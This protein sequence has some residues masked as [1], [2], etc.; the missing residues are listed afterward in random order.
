MTHPTRPAATRRPTCPTRRGAPRRPPLRLRRAVPAAGADGAPP[1]AAARA[2]SEIVADLEASAAGWNRADMAAHLAI[3][4]DSATFMTATGPIVGKASTRS[5]LERAFW[6]DGRPK[7]Q[8]RFERV[9]V[10]PLGRAP[11]ARDRPVHALGRGR[12]GPERLVSRSPWERTP[13]GVARAARPLVVSAAFTGAGA[14]GADSPRRAADALFHAPARVLRFDGATSR[15]RGCRRAS[16]PTR[17]GAGLPLPVLTRASWLRAPPT[18]ARARHGPPA[19]TSDAARA[20]ARGATRPAPPRMTAAERALLER[21]AASDGGLHLSHPRPRRGRGRRLRGGGGR[22]CALYARG[23]AT[24]PVTRRTA[25][26]RRAASPPCTPASPTSVGRCSTDDAPGAASVVV[27]TPG[28]G[29]PA[30]GAC[31]IGAA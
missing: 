4:A 24:R 14:R 19:T 29:S 6:R 21:L 27:L 23:Y 10:R 16:P 1:A 15:A 7:Q 9:A 5:A 11:R 30:R 18:R 2:S 13:A 28:S 17:G 20:R 25:R 26:T 3:Y 12:G 31:G 8:L 22:L